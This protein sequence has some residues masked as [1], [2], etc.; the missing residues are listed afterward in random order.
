MAQNEALKKENL[1]LEEELRT[2]KVASEAQEE[3]LNSVPK[4]MKEIGDTIQRIGNGMNYIYICI[5]RGCIRGQSSSSDDQGAQNGNNNL[6]FLPLPERAAEYE[7]NGVTSTPFTVGMDDGGVSNAGYG[8][9]ASEADL[10]D[11]DDLITVNTI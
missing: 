8:D 10:S 6:V 4:Y 2:I 7:T 1:A 3:L 5:K 9:H 11:D